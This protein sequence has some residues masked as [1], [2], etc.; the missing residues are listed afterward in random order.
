MHVC[1]AGVSLGLRT[2]WATSKIRRC[3]LVIQNG[4]SQA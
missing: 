1:P 3:R 4:A 2:M